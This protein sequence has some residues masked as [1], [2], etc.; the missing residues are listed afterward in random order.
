M[1][2]I[3]T[4]GHVDHGK[5]TL[6]RLLT[7]MEPD[8]WEQERRR[9]LTI[10]LGFAW[11]TLP[12]G[13]EVAFV[14]VPGHERFVPNML[15]GIGP[16]PAV[17]FV[18]AADEGW[19][20]QST[21]HL[22]ALDALGVRHALLAVTR[23]DLADPEP[24]RQQ[25]L[26]RMATTSVGPVDSVT[27]SGRTG[28]GLDRLRAALVRLVDALPP[29]DPDA[30]VRLWV[31]RSFSIV[32]AGT[33]VTGTLTAGTL[34]GDTELH[35]A[36][37]GAV[38]RVRGLQTLGR[39]TPEV[40]AV[41]RVAVNLRGVEHR[42]I[43]RGDALLTPGRWLS[44]AEVDVAL[45]TA[46]SGELRDLP[47]EL[48]LHVGSASVAARVRPLGA[49]SAR[50]RLARPLPLRVGDRALLRDPGRH[51]IAAGVDVLDVTPPELSRRGAARLRAEELAALTDAPPRA[52]AEAMLRRRHFAT[53][54]ELHAMGLPVTG[55]PVGDGRRV[56]P[57]VWRELIGCLRAEIDQWRDDH[58]LESGMPVEAVR[59]RLR[60]PTAGVVDLLAGAASLPVVEG[61][62][63]SP[64]SRAVLPEP[65]EAAVA[66]LAAEL[67]A[68]PFAAPDAV[69][70]AELRLGAKE[71]AAAVRAGRLLKVADG[72]FLL[73]DGDRRAAEVLGE[74][75]QPFTLS[76]ARQALRTTRR[77][78]VPL[79]ELLDRRGVTE[80]LPD[81][82]R[83]VRTASA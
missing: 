54:G 10:D 72:V 27:V 17:L 11:T 42:A 35:L 25:A 69:R 43:G 81:S 52:V 76:Q 74:L 14:D 37:T 64:G 66:A 73:P 45:R 78:A 71:L 80:R 24:A 44:T 82:T 51:R 61:R 6:V 34:R 32:G 79:L 49:G 7:G 28:E 20:P 50:L 60:L 13:A 56:H 31:D 41:A 15:A 38:L 5:S 62:V 33:V 70:M 63:C 21:E 48:V 9:G 36:S 67:R 2:V 3:A 75:P 29:A 19:M 1:H 16:V 68:A 12:G 40:S 58:P 22:E 53:E 57:G 18:V 30:D 8:R 23:C 55:E 46:D 39:D 47:R 77:V 4:A 83:R 26:A 59:R 65:V